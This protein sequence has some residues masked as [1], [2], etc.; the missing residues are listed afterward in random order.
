[1]SPGLC[2]CSDSPRSER[3]EDLGGFVSLICLPSCP[4]L[5]RCSIASSARK[6][7]L[8]HSFPG[9]GSDCPLPSAQRVFSVP[10]APERGEKRQSL[11]LAESSCQL[12]LSQ[13][14]P[15]SFKCALW[16]WL[17]R[18]D[19][20]LAVNKP[21]P[22]AA[23]SL[24]SEPASS[25]GSCPVSWSHIVFTSFLCSGLGFAGG[26]T[27]VVSAGGTASQIP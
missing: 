17:G 19:E 1:M 13:V 10:S 2:N 7:S 20:V 3:A 16:G 11:D 27:F 12:A 14:G 18:V 9:V 26:R 6:P 21:P 4:L 23:A 22:G 8:E 25:R 15:Q 24:P 5:L